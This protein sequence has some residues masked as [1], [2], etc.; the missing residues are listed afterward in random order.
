MLQILVERQISYSCKSIKMSNIHPD[1][2]MRNYRDSIRLAFENEKSLE[3]RS[4]HLQF[5][6]FIPKNGT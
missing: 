4:K 2:K 1:S 5:F 3:S 6:F